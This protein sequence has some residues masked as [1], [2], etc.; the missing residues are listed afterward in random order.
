MDEDLAKSVSGM[1]PL[2]AVAHFACTAWAFSNPDIL[3]KQGVGTFET[4]SFFVDIP[5]A[6]VG[7]SKGFFQVLL[8][9]RFSNC[10]AAVYFP[11][12]MFL[13]IIVGV[14]TH[15]L[16]LKHILAIL[17]KLLEL[18][19]CPRPLKTDVIED[20]P[21]YTETLPLEY[22]EKQLAED[23]GGTVRLGDKRR[24]IVEAAIQNRVKADCARVIAADQGKPPPPEPR[25]MSINSPVDY[26]MSSNSAYEFMESGDMQNLKNIICRAQTDLAGDLGH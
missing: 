22:L 4:S 25:L 9:D 5:S 21:N 20:L 12:V 8:F 11:F 1:L 6:S 13:L 19:L 17:H 16:F 3:S 15:K 7:E 24:L 10:V 18:C 26:N 2:T 14:I 23:E